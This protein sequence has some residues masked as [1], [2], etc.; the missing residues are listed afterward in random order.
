MRDVS[1][2]CLGKE[3]DVGDPEVTFHGI[4]NCHSEFNTREQYAT[5]KP[6]SYMKEFM[7]YMGGVDSGLIPDDSVESLYV[8]EE[9]MEKNV[10]NV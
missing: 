3:I 1:K 6:N 7:E 8:D 4:P 2:E 10:N 9:W 5:E